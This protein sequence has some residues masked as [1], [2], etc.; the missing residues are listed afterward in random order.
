MDWN[1]SPSSSRGLIP[2]SFVKGNICTIVDKKL[3]RGKMLAWTTLCRRPDFNRNYKLFLDY[4]E[5]FSILL[6]QKLFKLN[7]KEG[8]Q[9]L[10]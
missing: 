5:M 10:L 8:M 6:E 2:W 4:S 3:K 9:D 1:V 7:G